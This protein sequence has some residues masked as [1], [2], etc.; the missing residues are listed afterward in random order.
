ML[1]WPPAADRRGLVA[2][3]I[4]I[5][6]STLVIVPD[7]ARLGALVRHLQGAGHRVLVMRGDAAHGERTRAWSDARRG[8]CV[9]VGGRAA[10]WA[11][12]P[13]L[14]AVIVLDE[15]D[16][17]LQDERAPTWHA[18]DLM[19]ERAQRAG[20]AITL[21]AP[22]PTPEAEALVGPPVR[23]ERAIE[24]EGWPLLDVV[25]LREEAPGVGL[26]TDGLASAL[27]RAIDADGRALC[28]LNRK[29]RARLLACVKCRELTRCETCGAAVAESDAGTLVCAQCGTERP[30]VCLACHGTRLKAV[31]PGISRLREDLAALLPR[32][33]VA[34]VDASTEAVPNV[35]VLVGTE[36]VLH[37]I[38]AGTPVRVVAFLD[39]DQELAAPRYRAAQH[40]LALITRAARVLGP[41]ARGGR[42]LVQTRLPDHEVLETVRTA[43]PTPARAA[44]DQRRQ[45]LGYPPYGALAEVSGADQA[46]R[47]ALEPLAGRLDLSVL[48]PTAAGAGL[49]ALVRAAD[50][51]VL[52]DALAI[53]APLGRAAGRLRVAVDPPRV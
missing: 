7:G 1:A 33:Q 38:P 36:A 48:G 5:G 47:A 17:S 9:V 46:V 4:A 35:E 8:G 52:G 28:V 2:D 39:L 18:R 6:G 10:C 14:A 42:L 16:E 34:E 13:D 45:A 50:V 49:R 37:R 24:R 22:V 43:D 21:V 51:E 30:V 32:A 29:G 11:P 15:G 12:V 40:S 53:A 23:P 19:V 27:H 41:R 31:R 20:A 25:D 26:V 44:E 3:R